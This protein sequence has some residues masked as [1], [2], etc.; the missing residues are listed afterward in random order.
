MEEVV[1][2]I[3]EYYTNL[4]KAD[5][6]SWLKWADKRKR[7]TEISANAFF[8]GV[9]LDQGQKTERAWNGGIHLVENHF[10]GNG[11]FWKNVSTTHHATVKRICQKEFNGTSYASVYTYNKFHKWL[12]SA[13]SIMLEKYNGD[14]RNIWNVK[15]N[16]VD[17]IYKR[18]KE[19]DGIG[20]ALAK[21]AQ[22]A[23]V[24]MYGVAGGQ[25]SKS[26]M[27][28]KP[29]VLVSRVLFR[30]GITKTNRISDTIKSVEALQ[31]SSPADFDA[32]A[33]VIGRDYCTLSNP[34][35][36]SCPLE[37]ICLYLRGA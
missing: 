29:D 5:G 8:V 34:E 26:E 10:G 25:A 14:P 11:G 3:N 31:L 28:V 30:S 2:A 33:W 18:F 37:G 36:D 22:F 24:R 6:Y 20:D 9:I 4:T 7:F 13:A 12:R 1:T 35:C 21:M 32:A 15:A 17:D 16:K 27:S 19:F 23:L